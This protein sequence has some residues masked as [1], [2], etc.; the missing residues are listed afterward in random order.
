M[1]LFLLFDFGFCC[2]FFFIFFLPK[3]S[4]KPPEISFKESLFC[5][6]FSGLQITFL[7]VVLFV[8]VSR[9]MF[10]L[11]V[12][13]KKGHDSSPKKWTIFFFPPSASPKVERPFH[14]S[15]HLISSD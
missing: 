15:F 12:L 3:N 9:S 11:F 8:F 4:A 6:F 2:F 14:L 13:E 10:F 1:F 5:L 7:N